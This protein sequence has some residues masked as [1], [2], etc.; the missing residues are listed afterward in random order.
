MKRLNI[1]ITISIKDNN[2][3]NSGIV[4]NV[5]NLYL[6]LKNSPNNYNVFLA[7]TSKVE[8]LEYDIEDIKIVSL[9][10]VLND[11]DIIILVGSGLSNDYYNYL[12]KRKCK[13]VDYVCSAT[14]VMDAQRMLFNNNYTSDY[15]VYPPD[16]VWIIPQNFKM[17]EH[18]FKTIYRR[19]T[20]EAPFV[21]SPIFI[22][23]IKKKHNIKATYTPSNEPK[24]IS[25]F[26]PNI[27]M[28]K[29]AMYNVL[30][31]EEVYRT[32]PELIKH[33]YVT[34]ALQ[35]KNND[36][37]I[38]IMKKLDVVNNGIAT[39]E[40]RFMIPYFLDTFTDVVISHQW[41]NPLNYAY[42]DALYLNYPLVHNADIIKD[43]GYYY[44]GFDI[45]TA[46]E[47]LIF[48]LTEHDKNLDEYNH[49]SKL[50][51]DRYLPTNE[52]SI[53]TYDK[54]IDNLYKNK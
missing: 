5:V 6:L 40:G 19:K 18:Y 34:N 13:I 24:K 12:I 36:L 11:I 41:E 37:F 45:N 48:A 8:K 35:I 39:F 46:K 44:E 21:W 49:K 26:E 1:G 53:S 30:I 29:F 16:E 22:E 3:W 7:N 2:I 17:N 4:Q 43:A 47:K 38:K 9:E 28:V 51:L 23:Y 52:E 32:N 27:D 14:Y 33:L 31:V 20:I 54:M 10:K 25:S 42:L 50:V 15:F